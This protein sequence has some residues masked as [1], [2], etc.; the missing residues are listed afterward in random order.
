MNDPFDSITPRREMKVT[1]PL[2]RIKLHDPRSREHEYG[3]KRL[4]SASKVNVRHAMNAPHVDQFYLGG[5]VGFSGTNWLNSGMAVRNRRKFNSVYHHNRSS[6]YLDN[7]DG[8]ENYSSATLYDPWP[9]QY[10]PTDEGSSAIGL[11]KAWQRY[12]VITSYSWTFTFDQFLAALQRQP[13]L[14]GS[15]WYDDMMSTDTNGLVTS[16]A[17][18]PGGGHEYLGSEIIW[19]KRRFGQPVIGYE[20]SWG[21][22]PPHF[23]KAG[24]FWMGFDLAEEL[25]INQEG[26]VAVPTLL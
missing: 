21:E 12:G 10:P 23:G 22:N 19:D 11:M 3:R 2:G 8:I 20:Q 18:G 9:G 5:C 7:N 24:R 14:V 17:S 15:N 25:I 13:V 16:S 1:N 6:A 26:D 4:V